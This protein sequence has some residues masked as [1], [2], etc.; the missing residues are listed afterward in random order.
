MGSIRIVLLRKIF[1]LFFCCRS[2]QYVLHVCLPRGP[3]GQVQLPES[4]P[5]Q[6]TQGPGG[7][8]LLRMTAE[9]RAMGSGLGGRALH[10]VSSSASSL[11]ELPPPPAVTPAWQGG[12]WGL[13]ALDSCILEGGVS[14]RRLLLEV[15]R[16]VSEMRLTVIAAR[17]LLSISNMS[18]SCVFLVNLNFGC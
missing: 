5:A 8:T 16:R 3:S 17:I 12:D 11:N 15:C 1:P 14:S 7:R 18:P 2:Y 6:A 10:W 9:L 4:E 13:I